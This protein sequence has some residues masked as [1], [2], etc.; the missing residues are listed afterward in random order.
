MRTKTSKNAIV[1]HDRRSNIPTVIHIT[2]IQ[3][4]KLFRKISKKCSKGEKV[5]QETSVYQIS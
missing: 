1:R 4:R 5:R 2:T 3:G